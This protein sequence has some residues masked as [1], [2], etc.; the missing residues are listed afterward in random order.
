MYNIY[1]ISCGRKTTYCNK[2]TQHLKCIKIFTTS[3]KNWANIFLRFNY[4]TILTIKLV[5][6]IGEFDLLR[7]L[8]KIDNSLRLI[9]KQHFYS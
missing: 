8:Q 7:Y 6:Q 4:K 3:S 2:Q 9:S 1:K 5:K